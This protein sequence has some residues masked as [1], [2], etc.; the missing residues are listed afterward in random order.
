MKNMALHNFH[1]GNLEKPHD[2]LVL[3]VLVFSCV[4][5]IG[6]MHAVTGDSSNLGN[7]NSIGRYY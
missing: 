6:F 3:S 1:K 2:S 7:I 4:G 5:R